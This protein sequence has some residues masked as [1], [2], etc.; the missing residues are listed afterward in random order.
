MKYCNCKQWRENM[1]Y[2][3]LAEGMATAKEILYTGD[4]FVYCPWCGLRLGDDSDQYL[5]NI[6]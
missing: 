2:F 3:H 1:V 4:K 6:I 5:G